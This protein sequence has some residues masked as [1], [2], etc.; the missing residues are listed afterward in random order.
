[1]S[2]I[3]LIAIHWVAENAALAWCTTRKKEE[4]CCCIGVLFKGIK[5]ILIEISK[6]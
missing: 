5:N 2:P 4:K 3:T 1:M 6:N